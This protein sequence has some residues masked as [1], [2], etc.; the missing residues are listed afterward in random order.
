MYLPLDRGKSRALALVLIIIGWILLPDFLTLGTT[1]GAD[2]LNYMIGVQLDSLFG[3]EQGY[4]AYLTFI[5]AGIMF[6]G[7]ILIFPYNTKIMLISTFRKVLAFGMS[8]PFLAIIV[9]G[10]SIYLLVFGPAI[11]EQLSNQLLDYASTLGG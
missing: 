4:G 6:I 5:I 1:P 10:I 2:M 8:H 9:I 11:A 7:G 3:L